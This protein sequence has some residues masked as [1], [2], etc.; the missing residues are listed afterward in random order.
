MRGFDIRG[1]ALAAVAFEQRAVFLGVAAAAN[2]QD[3]SSE[4]GVGWKN[5]VDQ[6]DAPRI[7]PHTVS[8]AQVFG[9]SQ[10]RAG[11]DGFARGTEN[12]LRTVEAH[13]N[14]SFLDAA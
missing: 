13:S 1:P 6:Q 4:S 3:A 14:S 8:V 10:N 5:P 11:Q 12:G 7:S 2:P 9:P